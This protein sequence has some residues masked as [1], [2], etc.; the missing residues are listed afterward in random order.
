[1]KY[2]LSV[3]N[4]SIGNCPNWGAHLAGGILLLASWEVLLFLVNFVPGVESTVFCILQAHGPPSLRGK[5]WCGQPSLH[6]GGE[7]EQRMVMGQWYG[8]G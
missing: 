3:D 4:S 6:L 8:V 5:L 1:M 2:A 7:L